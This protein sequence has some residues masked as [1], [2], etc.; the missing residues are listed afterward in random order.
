MICG[1]KMEMLKICSKSVYETLRTSLYRNR[2]YMDQKP[3]LC[4]QRHT[5]SFRMEI[6]LMT[7]PPSS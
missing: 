4:T 2:M 6:N 7:F 1:A 5:Q 3:L